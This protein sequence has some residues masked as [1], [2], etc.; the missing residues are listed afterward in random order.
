MST[1]PFP[2]PQPYRA[3]D[4]NRF[5]GREDMVYALKGA[6]L[7]R[8]CVTVYGPSGAG[9]SSLTQAAVLPALVE[10]VAA[11]GMPAVFSAHQK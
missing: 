1:N 8:R 3:T 5:F 10:A 2:G 9:K 6:I 7:A 4:R 11:A